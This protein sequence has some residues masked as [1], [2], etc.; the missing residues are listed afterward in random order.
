MFS[1]P[2]KYDAPDLFIGYEGGYRNSWECATGAVTP[3]VF[4]DNT[5]SWS[6][7]HCVDPAIVPGI[8]FCNRP[9]ATERP[10]LIDIATSVLRLFG[11]EP[12]AHMPGRFLFARP[13]EQAPVRGLLDPGSLGQSGAAPGARIFPNGSH[14]VSDAV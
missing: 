11:Q 9:I 7:D 3:D 12:P 5:K 8:F 13:G 2:Q 1:G 4:T 6:G 14:P 10:H